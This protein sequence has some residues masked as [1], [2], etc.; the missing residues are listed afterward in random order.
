MTTGEHRKGNSMKLLD[1]IDGIA[2]IN[3][4]SRP[5]R[6]ARFMEKTGCYFPEKKIHRISAVNGR[7]LSTYGKLPWF[8]EATG[9]RAG[10]WGG[11]GGCAL[12]HRKAIEWARENKLRHVLVF[13]DDVVAEVHEGIAELLN[14]ALNNLSGAYM[15]YL[16]YNKPAPYGKCCMKS[17]EVELW[18]TEGVI[19]AHA[20]IVSAE[21]YDELLNLMPTENNIWE[22]LSQYR[23][24]D[25]LYRDFVPF[26]K[27][28][29]VYVLHPVV[30]VQD[31]TYSDIGQTSFAGI[32]FACRQ[33]PRCSGFL[34]S[35]LKPLLCLKHKCN[36][37]RTHR[38]ALKGGLPGFRKS[39]KK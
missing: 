21:L 9:D 13:E 12:S 11:T 36:S 24:I 1:N 31:D 2:V 16:G 14:T 22:W 10:F 30:C 26:L 7:E 29:S 37:V 38:R 17:G 6:F 19:A 33:A 39:H 32:D 5:D 18:K 3:M 25:V 20:Y 4:D 35:I 27:N 34:R 23:A 8:T 15:L 28:V